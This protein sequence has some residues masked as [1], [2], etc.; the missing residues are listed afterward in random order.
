WSPAT[1]DH[2]LTDFPLTGAHISVPCIECHAN[3]YS[4]T[5]T[6]CYSCH[7]DDYNNTSD[8]NHQAAGFPITCESCHNTISWNQTTWNHDALYF[9]IYSGKHRN[10]WD[11]C[12]DCHVNSNDFTVFE[13]I[14]CHEHNRQ[15]M[16]SEHNDVPGYQ[17]LSSACYNCHPRGESFSRG[18]P[19]K[20]FE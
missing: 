8:P 3:G 16:D 7:Q 15:D 9:P 20:S 13:C 6:N 11:I 19:I 2:N 5:P 12:A 10:K 4:G 18:K 17:Y 14:F 1:F